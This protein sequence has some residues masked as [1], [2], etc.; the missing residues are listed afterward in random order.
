MV[1]R[2]TGRIGLL[3]FGWA[4]FLPAEAPA[5]MVAVPGPTQGGMQGGSAMPP[6]AVLANPYLNPYMN[7]YLNSA[8]TQRPMSA[9]N[10]ALY[11]YTANA[12]RGGIGSGKLGQAKAVAPRPKVAE[13]PDASA[14]P[15]AGAAR[16]FNPGP[17]NV[18]GAGK[19]YGR[20]NRYFQN[21]GR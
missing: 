8:A 9:G 2:W 15:G 10:A 7:P 18:N 13:M 21:N 17:V 11:M 19:Y 12:A 6:A 4:M 1:G 3:A 20:R 16:F 5:Q 14:V